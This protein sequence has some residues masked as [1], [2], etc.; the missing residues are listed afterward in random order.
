MVGQLTG[1]RVLAPFGQN[2]SKTV[3]TQAEDLGQRGEQAR[4]RKYQEGAST[5]ADERA[6]AEQAWREKDALAERGLQYAK[7]NQAERLA[8]ESNALRRTIEAEKIKAKGAAKAEA[9]KLGSSADQKAALA[10]ELADRAAGLKTRMPAGA[11]NAGKDLA[12]DLTSKVWPG[13]A[14]ALGEKLYDKG[15]DPDSWRADA[16]SFDQDVSNLAA[17]LAVTGFE[18]ENKQKWS[19]RAPG[20]S[21][22]ESQNRFDNMQ[23][24]FARRAAALRGEGNAYKGASAAPAADEV[25]TA[26][27]AAELAALEAQFGGG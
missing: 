7:L 16:D 6:Q 22:Q 26:E 12:V 18:L 4:Y 13:A 8:G 23:S 9:L 10:E 24:K 17:G 14:Q 21:A 25:L 2:L 15:L 27:E 11:I 19:P 1:D 3:N 20:I 5:R